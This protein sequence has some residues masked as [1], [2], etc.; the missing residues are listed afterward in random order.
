MLCT[1][2]TTDSTIKQ[3]YIFERPQDNFIFYVCYLVWWPL[4]AFRKEFQGSHLST[5]SEDL[6]VCALS[7]LYSTSP[8]RQLRGS[9]EAVHF[10]LFSFSRGK[11]WNDYAIKDTKLLPGHDHL[12][13]LRNQIRSTL[14]QPHLS[15][16]LWLEPCTLRPSAK[17]TTHSLLHHWHSAWC[18]G[19]RVWFPQHGP[20]PA[21]LHKKTEVLMF[22]K[23]VKAL[24]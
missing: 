22:S 19:S 12:I 9:R 1:C 17:T 11:W 4:G 16:D 8:L 23:Q 10:G 15:A 13:K 3:S 21:N 20:T 5:S 2:I 7:L 14:E 6:N 18:S 24:E